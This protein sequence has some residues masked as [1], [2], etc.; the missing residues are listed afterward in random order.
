[1]NA[2]KFNK[3]KDNC[4]FTTDDIAE[5]F[6]ISTLLV[7]GY[8]NGEVEIPPLVNL[9][10]EYVS[11]VNNYQ[12]AREAIKY[13][14]SLQKRYRLCRDIKGKILYESLDDSDKNYIVEND[15]YVR[16][17]LNLVPSDRF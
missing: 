8:E 13:S 9:A 4:Y 17:W 2:T 11:I 10:C 14:S 12:S 3:W 15:K 1:M 5:L 7:K 16:S 6:G